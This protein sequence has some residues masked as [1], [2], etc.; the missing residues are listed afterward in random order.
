MVLGGVLHHHQAVGEQLSA[1]VLYL[2]RLTIGVCGLGHQLR[3]SLVA[4]LAAGGAELV[5][6]GCK[7]PF[8]A[9][10]VSSALRL[11]PQKRADTSG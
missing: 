3:G 4:D 11:V 6:I 10:G 5:E 7:Q 8:K 2:D 9:S 1:H